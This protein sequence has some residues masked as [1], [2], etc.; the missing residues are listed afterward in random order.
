MD[1]KPGLSTVID[2]YVITKGIEDCCKTLSSSSNNIQENNMATGLE[3]W[4]NKI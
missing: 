4:S 2:A 3:K 1:Q